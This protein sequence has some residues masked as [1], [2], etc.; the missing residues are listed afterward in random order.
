MG[1]AIELALQNVEAAAAAV[2]ASDPSVR[3]FGVARH[4]SGFG[5]RAVRNSNVVVAQAAQIQDRLFDV[6]IVFTST[7]GEVRSL[8]T[9]PGAGMASPAS[10]SLWPPGP[11]LDRGLLC[12][13]VR[14]ARRRSGRWRTRGGDDGHEARL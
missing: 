10:T 11:V 13:A 8:V 2:F 3:S 5:F 12:S 14:C 7:P 4:D 6:P 1:V 9:V